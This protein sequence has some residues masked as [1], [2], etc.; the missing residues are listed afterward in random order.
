[1]S[2]FLSVPGRGEDEL[3]LQ[4]D[5]GKGLATVCR[6]LDSRDHLLGVDGSPVRCGP[7]GC[8]R[9]RVGQRAGAADAVGLFGPPTLAMW[10]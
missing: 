4:S 10:N 9:S 6:N 5:L 1:M 7:G 8:C 3:R 2:S